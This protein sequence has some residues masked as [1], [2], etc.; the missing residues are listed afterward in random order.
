MYWRITSAPRNMRRPTSSLPYLTIVHIDGP[1]KQSVEVVQRLKILRTYSRFWKA[2]KSQAPTTTE[3]NIAKKLLAQK[4]SNNS[5]P[6]FLRKAGNSFNQRLES[7]RGFDKN[8]WVELYVPHDLIGQLTLYFVISSSSR[9]RQFSSIRLYLNTL[10]F[11][12]Y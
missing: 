8:C 9:S 10:L 5:L 6:E 4:C 12:Q 2:C 11:Y 7:S 3:K 1:P